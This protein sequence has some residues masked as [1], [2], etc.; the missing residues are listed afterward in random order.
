MDGAV[1]VAVRH[2][3]RELRKP[4]ERAGGGEPPALGRQE[5]VEELA[6]LGAGGRCRVRPG[7]SGGGALGVGERTSQSSRVSMQLSPFAIW[8]STRLT[9]GCGGGGG[10]RTD[11]AARTFIAIGVCWSSPRERWIGPPRPC[12]R[13]ERMPGACAGANSPP[14]GRLARITPD[15][16]SASSS[17]SLPAAPLPRRRLRM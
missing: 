10:P 15:P 14:D 8:L 9:C 13:S 2:R 1:L 12:A 3:A 4:T 5:R 7:R 6:R 11:A 16:A 17:A